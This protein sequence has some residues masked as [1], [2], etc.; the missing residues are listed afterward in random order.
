[1]GVYFKCKPLVE[2]LT[3]TSRGAGDPDSA[4]EPLEGACKLMDSRQSCAST[5]LR[6]DEKESVGRGFSALAETN[7]ARAAVKRSVAG[8]HR[9]LLPS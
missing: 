1:M 7:V 2:S 4:A 9:S 6:G 5:L 8:T 3:G